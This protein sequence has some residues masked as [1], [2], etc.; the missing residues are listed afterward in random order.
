MKKSRRKTRKEHRADQL[1]DQ[2]EHLRAYT[3]HGRS[4]QMEHRFSHRSPIRI[5][6]YRHDTILNDHICSTNRCHKRHQLLSNVPP[7]DAM[8]IKLLSQSQVTRRMHRPTS[9]FARTPTHTHMSEPEES[10]K[11]S[12]MSSYPGTRR[13]CPSEAPCRANVTLL[14]RRHGRWT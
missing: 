6:K 7:S 9:P 3:G 12:R 11:T 13:A 4:H 10:Q 1:S 5:G 8:I 2:V 14:R